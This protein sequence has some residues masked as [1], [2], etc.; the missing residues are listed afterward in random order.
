MISQFRID[1]YES[2]KSYVTRS[3]NED[4]ELVK[5]LWQYYKD[6]GVEAYQADTDDLQGTV[7]WELQGHWYTTSEIKRIYNLR[8]F[9]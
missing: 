1:L 9:L 5:Q 4:P 6:L 8:A 3:L 2:D 7:R